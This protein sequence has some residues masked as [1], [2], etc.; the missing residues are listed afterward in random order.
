MSIFVSLASYRDDVCS[1]TLVDLYK[2]A[3]NPLLVF[4]GICQQNHPDD[5][6]CIQSTVPDEFLPNIRIIKLNHWEAKG[7]QI[8]RYYCSKLWN[9]ETYYLQIDSHTTFVQDWDIKCIKM[10]NQLKSL[11]VS[12]KPV[13]SYYPKSFGTENDKSLDV[14]R[15]CKSFFNNRGMISFMGS[16]SLP[17]T[18]IPYNTPHLA[19]GFFFCESYFLN[20]LPYDPS[21]DYLFVGEEILHSARFY[22]HGWDIFTP[23]ENIVYHEYTR[24]EKPKIW[25]DLTYSDKDA[26]QKVK[27]LLGLS[28]NPPPEYIMNNVEKYGLGTTRSLSDFY[29]FAGIDIKSKTTF[30]N[31]CRINN[32]DDTYVA[33]KPNKKYYVYVFCICLSFALIILLLLLLVLLPCKF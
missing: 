32:I 4:V 31:F 19:S 5:L 22:T 21:L 3:S 9:N 28:K 13:L 24:K 6:D 11:G 7:P 15:M 27:Y 8:A 2:K 33:P 26:L 17:Q 23:T 1:S 10:I 25:T 14:P 29:N 16:E 18:E 12:N 30:K 20:E